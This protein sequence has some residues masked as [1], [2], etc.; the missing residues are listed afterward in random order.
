MWPSR[1]VSSWANLNAASPKASSVE[2]FFRPKK[3]KTDFANDF[4]S[5]HV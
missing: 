4:V 5:C 3:V 1:L 2:R